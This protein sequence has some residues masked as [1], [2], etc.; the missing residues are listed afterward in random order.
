MWEI[1]AGEP[2][3]GSSEVDLT[4][5][6]SARAAGHTGPEDII[7]IVCGLAVSVVRT[8]C[9]LMPELIRPKLKLQAVVVGDAGIR[10][11]PEDTFVTV[12][13]SDSLGY[14]CLAGRTW[15][16]TSRDEVR[17]RGGKTRD[18]RI[19]VDGLV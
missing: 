10:A 8:E 12:D 13:A 2:V 9:Q 14:H 11:L 17:K 19:P 7:N 5:R 4:L 16:F 15:C 3:F 6:E 18:F 1:Q